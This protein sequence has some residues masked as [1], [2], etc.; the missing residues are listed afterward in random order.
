[1]RATDYI[2]SYP[3]IYSEEVAYTDDEDS[4]GLLSADSL[5]KSVTAVVDLNCER[6]LAG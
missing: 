1:M 3:V 6:A 4:H 2:D 5:Q